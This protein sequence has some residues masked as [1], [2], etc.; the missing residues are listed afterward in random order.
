M[1][2]SPTRAKLI[3][4]IAGLHTSGLS[5]R[6]AAEGRGLPAADA[7]AG[8]GVLVQL[9]DHAADEQPDAAVRVLIPGG[10]PARPTPGLAH[11]TPP[12]RRLKLCTL[13]N[14]AALQESPGPAPP[15]PEAGPEPERL[16]ARARDGDAAVG[17]Q[18]EVEDALAVA[19]EDAVARELGQPPDQDLVERVAVRRD[20]RVLRARPGE[21][22]DLGP[23]VDG[24][25]PQ[26]LRCVPN[27]D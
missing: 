23:R 1:S 20:E 13:S 25:Q 15:P 12:R 4:T 5:R 27:F 17:R 10:P 2:D 22:A 14:P 3:K 6:R 24:R 26:A 19:R 18:R 21:G 11:Y 7:G 9:R 16:V 8:E